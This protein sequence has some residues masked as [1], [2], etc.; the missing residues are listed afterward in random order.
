MLPYPSA[1]ETPV[2]T[3]SEARP[4]SGRSSEMTG[5]ALG[6]LQLPLIPP[7]LDRSSDGSRFALGHGMP[8]GLSWHAVGVVVACRGA[9]HGMP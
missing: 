1:E 9:R 7:S 6:T 4:S 8:W 2:G 5:L 3:Q